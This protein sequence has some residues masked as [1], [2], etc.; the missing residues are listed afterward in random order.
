VDQITLTSEYFVYDHKHVSIALVA[1]VLSHSLTV[2]CM[3]RCK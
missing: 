3:A 2:S 1:F